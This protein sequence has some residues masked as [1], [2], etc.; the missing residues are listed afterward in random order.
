MM[1]LKAVLA[2]VLRNFTI[3]SLQKR[4]EIRPNPGIVLQP[5]QGIWVKLIEHA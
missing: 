4:E 2:T 1:E 5:E 3:Q